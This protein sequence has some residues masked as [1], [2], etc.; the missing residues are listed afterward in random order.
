MFL[1]VDCNFVG[2]ILEGGH[3][4]CD[5]PEGGEEEWNSWSEAKQEEWIRHN[6]TFILD[7]YDLEDYDLDM[8]SV[9]IFK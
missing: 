2:G 3:F 1:E 4:E 6:G 7:L 5:L 9:K 8:N